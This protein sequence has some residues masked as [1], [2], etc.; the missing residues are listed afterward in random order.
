V[1]G[2]RLRWHLHCHGGVDDAHPAVDLV[3]IVEL[4]AYVNNGA[5][6]VSNV[7]HDN[8]AKAVVETE[9]SRW[10]T[11]GHGAV[12]ARAGLIQA[13]GQVLKFGSAHISV[14]PG[15]NTSKTR[16]GD[17]AHRGDCMQSGQPVVRALFVIVPETESKRI[18]HNLQENDGSATTTQ[19]NAKDPQSICNV[20][21]NKMRNWTCNAM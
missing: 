14:V 13:R 18:I 7:K 9:S 6:I 11:L 21:C 16:E 17:K 3:R 8:A 19:T 1:N 20:T 10:Q 12:H 2:K 4:V 5:K 15:G